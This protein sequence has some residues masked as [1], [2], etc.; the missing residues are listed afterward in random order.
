MKE[1]VYIKYLFVFLWLKPVVFYI[2]RSCFGSACTGGMLNQPSISPSVKQWLQIRPLLLVEGVRRAHERSV[3]GRDCIAEQS[4]L[5]FI[6]DPSSC[7]MIV[8][9]AVG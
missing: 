9:H 1:L 3:R 2:Q 6:S 7:E 5:L 8:S 4:L